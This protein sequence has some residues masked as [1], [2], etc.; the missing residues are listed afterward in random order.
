M[1]RLIKLENTARFL[2]DKKAGSEMRAREGLKGIPLHRGFDLEEIGHTSRAVCRT[3]SP[4]V[5][6]M[7][8]SP[9]AD[10]TGN[11]NSSSC[12]AVCE[13]L[14]DSEDHVCNSLTT[15]SRSD[16]LPTNHRPSFVAA[17]DCRQ[18]VA[19]RLVLKGAI[20][21]DCA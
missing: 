19:G 2:D 6:S 12:T 13:F 4:A 3:F 16:F 10:S 14:N 18:D 5:G 15:F 9:K 8:R 17:A 11:R 20:T 1:S 21:L 7:L